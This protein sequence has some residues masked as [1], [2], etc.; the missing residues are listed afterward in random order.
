MKKTVN[1]IL[2]AFIVLL[3]VL[4]FTPSASAVESDEFTIVWLTDTQSIAYHRFGN[5]AETMGKW[6]ADNAE[7]SNTR[8]VVHT[9]DLVDNGASERQWKNYD[10]LFDQFKDRLP[11]ISAAGNHDVKENGYLEYLARPEIQ[12]IPAD[13]AYGQGKASFATF[14]ASGEQFIIVAIGYGIEMEAASWAKE[15]LQQHSDYTAILI[16]HDYLKNDGEL[17]RTGRAVFSEIV[18]PNDNIRL[19]LCGH[20][21]GTSFRTD[22]IDGRTVT[23][24]MYNYQDYSDNCGQIRTLIFNTTERTLRV[25][26]YSPHT[27]KYYKDSTMRS[28][29][30]TIA[31]AF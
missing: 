13:N 10:E 20:A 25:I 1:R 15:V 14:E 9:G 5:A 26:T 27:G 24:M 29:D 18:T 31:N 30:F 7:E 16:L 3:F 22:E 6:I 2:A 19:V 17:S 23:A 28:A 11:F 8:Y 4:A 12:S 21:R